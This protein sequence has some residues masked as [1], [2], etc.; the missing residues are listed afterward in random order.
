MWLEMSPKG[1]SHLMRCEKPFGNIWWN[2]RF[3]VESW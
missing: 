3:V 1:I 2:K